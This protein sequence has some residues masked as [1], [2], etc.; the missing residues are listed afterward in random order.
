MIMYVDSDEIH[1]PEKLRKIRKI[2]LSGKYD[3]FG[4]SQHQYIKYP[5]LWCPAPTNPF[6]VCFTVNKPLP[7]YIRNRKDVSTYNFPDDIIYYKHMSYCP[8]D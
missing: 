2:I 8:K 4:I 6:P 7:S 3:Q 1:I 5:N